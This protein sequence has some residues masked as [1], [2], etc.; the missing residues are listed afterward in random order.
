MV[1][2]EA[3]RALELWVNQLRAELCA[4]K[5]QLRA[6]LAADERAADE[7]AAAAQ[8]REAHVQRV[9]LTLAETATEV[10]ELREALGEVTAQCGQRERELRQ[11]RTEIRSEH[12]RAALLDGAR[13]VRGAMK[14]AV[15]ERLDA[16]QA[17]LAAVHEESRAQRAELS[18]LRTQRDAD[19]SKRSQERRARKELRFAIKE[20][21]GV[22]ETVTSQMKHSGPPNRHAGVPMGGT[23]PEQLQ[24][25]VQ[26][27]Q[28]LL[29]SHTP[30]S[31]ARRD[32]DGNATGTHQVLEESPRRERESA[33][34]RRRQSDSS[35]AHGD[36]Q[37][38][39]PVSAALPARPR[40]TAR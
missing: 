25:A 37:R 32:S 31:P 35:P 2:A 6:A 28:S 26:R 10:V 39:R 21:M 19:E 1:S 22:I 38:R 3:Q 13:K 14:S 9:E 12:A 34:R 18:L 20:I 30:A 7:L 4:T 16:A 8:Q 33:S 23:P 11:L 15:Q 40:T 5:A 27:L 36:E 17:E 29:G 24:R